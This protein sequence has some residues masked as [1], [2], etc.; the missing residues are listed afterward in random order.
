MEV[1]E[2][3]KV[4]KTWAETLELR[5]PLADYLFAYLPVYNKAILIEF[6]HGVPY[7][8]LH[9][10]KASISVETLSTMLK[11]RKRRRKTEDVCIAKR[12]NI[13]YIYLPERSYVVK[14]IDNELDYDIPDVDDYNESIYPLEDVTAIEYLK[15]RCK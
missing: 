3:L 2:D 4:E 9:I 15:E 12:D 8:R 7:G 11:A 1:A 10:G 13:T 5:H 14:F 6:V